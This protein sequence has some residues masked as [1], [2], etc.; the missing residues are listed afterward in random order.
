MVRDAPADALLVADGFS[1]KTQIEQLG[2]REALHLAQVINKTPVPP[3][4]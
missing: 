4:S 2:G 3:A 1:C